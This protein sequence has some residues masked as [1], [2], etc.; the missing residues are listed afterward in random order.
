MDKEWAFAQLGLAPTTDRSQ[1]DR[2]Y[3]QAIQCYPKD[4]YPS[5]FQSIHEAY[6]CL[7][8]D[9]STTEPSQAPGF[10]PEGLNPSLETF[11]TLIAQ[12]D[13][14]T[15][16]PAP[17]QRIF[18]LLDHHF[19]TAVQDPEAFANQTQLFCWYWYLG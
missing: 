4:T 12:F 1:I 8:Q 5:E 9:L 18:E 11:E 13:Q 14:A 16:G 2:A 3:S 6:G 10:N 7:T 17:N 15:Q 19:A